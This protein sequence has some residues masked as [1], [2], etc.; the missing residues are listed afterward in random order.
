MQTTFPELISRIEAM[1]N[2]PRHG[3]MFDNA[4]SN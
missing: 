2:D 3:F 4:E 1:R